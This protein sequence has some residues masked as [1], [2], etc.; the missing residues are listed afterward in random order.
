MADLQNIAPMIGVM[1]YDMH[2]SNPY[3]GKPDQEVT[4]KYNKWL[5]EHKDEGIENAPQM[6]DGKARKC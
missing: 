4:D 2:S 1:G 6:S 3:Y 5:K